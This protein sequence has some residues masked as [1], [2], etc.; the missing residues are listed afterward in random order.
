MSEAI[1]ETTEQKQAR[2][3]AALGDLAELADTPK[4]PPQVS[5]K[6]LR[7]A[8][9][10]RAL[11]EAA[12]NGP[13]ATEKQ[14]FVIAPQGSMSI[15]GM[16]RTATTQPTQVDN[17]FERLLPIDGN[18]RA[19]SELMQEWNRGDV[20]HITSAIIQ[21]HGAVAVKALR[22][23]H[24]IVCDE[25][26]LRSQIE[27][28][29]RI[30]PAHSTDDI[31]AIAAERRL[32]MNGRVAVVIPSYNYAA[33]V[34]Q[35]VDSVLNQTWPVDEVIVVD[36]ASTD[37][38]VAKLE[39]YVLAGKIKLIQHAKNSGTVGAS[40]NTGIAATDAEFIV[41]LDADDMIKP[42]YVETCLAAIKDRHERGVVYTGVQSLRES[43]GNVMVHQGWPPDF[44]W[45]FMSAR[46]IPANNCIPTASMFRREMWLRAGGYDE[47]MR[48]TEDVEFW[49]RALGVGFEAVKCT[50]APYFVYRRHGVSMSS[51]P[52][53]DVGAWNAN[54]NGFKPLA[55]PLDNS[56]A[57]ILRNY[58]HPA[59][60]VIIPVG[61]GHQKYLRTALQ[62]LL[63]QTA[64]D[65]E[66]VLVNDTG[67]PLA[68][69][70]H[71]YAHVT[72]CIGHGVANARNT[73]VSVARAP[74]VFFLDADDYLHPDTLRITCEAYANAGGGV[75]VYTGWT[76]VHE[77]G[78]K[79]PYK[80]AP[81]DQAEFLNPASKGIHGVSVLI[82][83]DNYAEVGGFDPAVPWFEDLE[84]FARCAA[85]GLCGV[86]VQEPLLFYRV[87]TGDRHNHARTESNRAGYS[88]MIADKYG[89][90]LR[91][92]R[93][94]CGSCG[95]KADP[96]A[97]A[98]HMAASRGASAFAASIAGPGEK[99]MVYAGRKITA[100][101][102]RFRGKYRGWS[103][104]PP[105]PVANE[106]V[107]F[108]LSTTQ[109]IL[110]PMPALPQDSAH[111]PMSA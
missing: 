81:Y 55:A 52:Q 44:S 6:Q 84:F 18:G 67:S 87:H 21:Q 26:A 14:D 4:P 71:P 43:D 104:M 73:G 100:P 49:I 28:E 64:P 79:K 96:L 1:A 99:M 37:D 15:A 10:K 94:A 69:P 16:D 53:S 23:A 20:V 75:Y 109:W 65:W 40:R 29:M 68:V 58:S 27:R 13:R 22:A 78:D 12:M 25:D 11:A 107:D 83:K 32:E 111:V 93:M 50:D 36:D 103:G 97:A 110:A 39:P 19:V 86:A 35:A 46:K 98:N 48:S 56:P 47:G 101:S 34:T 31:D 91:G 102:G 41:C 90:A 106:D 72:D 60:S 2:L 77:N 70:G 33:F 62:S 17:P 92:E 95:R 51:R 7:E 5:R 85:K 63:A 82:A 108:M 57:P 42:E 30:T 3:R 66:V 61:P 38:T 80:A 105:I 8:A 89:A 76:T 9:H 59:V 88:A 24:V 54:F 45:K 74:L